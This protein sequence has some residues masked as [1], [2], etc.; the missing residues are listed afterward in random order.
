[1]VLQ[2]S[3]LQPTLGETCNLMTKIVMRRP[4]EW[5]NRLR[6]YKL[7]L[8]GVETGI[9]ASD[10]VQGYVIP[11]GETQDAYLYRVAGKRGVC[12]RD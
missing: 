7:I 6:S 5:S 11:P 1:M 4:P 2:N 9:I 8:N 3:A 12:F 10:E